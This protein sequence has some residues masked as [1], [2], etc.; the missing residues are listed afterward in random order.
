MEVARE[1]DSHFAFLS[2]GFYVSRQEPIYEPAK[3]AASRVQ[4]GRVGTFWCIL[5]ITNGINIFGA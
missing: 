5:L 2:I 4:T 1:S 3:V